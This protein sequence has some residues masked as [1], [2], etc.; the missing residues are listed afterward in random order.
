MP[1]D[2]GWAARRGPRY[3][4]PFPG[5]L[6]P[7]P[8]CTV[9]MRRALRSIYAAC[10]TGVAWMWS[11]HDAQTMRVLRRIFAMRAAH[12]GWPGPGLPSWLSAATWWTA[13]VAPCSH[14]SRHHLGVNL[15]WSVAILAIT[16]A[17]RVWTVR[18]GGPRAVLLAL[19][20]L[21]EMGYDMFRFLYF[22]RSLYDA[23]RRRQTSWNHVVR[24]M[25]NGAP[26]HRSP[27]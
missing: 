2:V 17:E 6:P 10:V 15:A 26:D 11:W 1:I 21:Q 5:S 16:L 13:T 4:G 9:S 14:R 20:V 18:R 25:S 12:A 23:A 3:I 8:V 7:N 19:A 24:S 22:F 27:A